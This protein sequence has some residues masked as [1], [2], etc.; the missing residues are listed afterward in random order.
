MKT[1]VILHSGI[2]RFKWP[3]LTG[4]LVPNDAGEVTVY[5]CDVEMR[6]GQDE[7]LQ[8][9][10]L[11]TII[12]TSYS[13]P[14]VQNRIEHIATKIRLAFFDHIFHERHYEKPIVP[15]ESIR[16]IEQHLFS[17]GSSPGDTSHDQS[18]EV[19]MQWDAK[20]HAYSGPSWKKAQIIYN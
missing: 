10:K 19:T 18:L 4:H 12:I 11:V 13:P 20:K 15:E 1:E 8:E 9:G 7:D 16:W 2:Y 6:V 3:Y 5:D 14:G 17:K